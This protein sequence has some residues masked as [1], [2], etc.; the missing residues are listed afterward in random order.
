MLVQEELESCDRTQR[1]LEDALDNRTAELYALR[2]VCTLLLS[3]CIFN[4]ADV[5]RTQL[6]CTADV[7]HTCDV[8]NVTS[9]QSQQ[10]IMKATIKVCWAGC[11]KVDGPMLLL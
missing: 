2:K 3:A 8:I 1:Q 11:Y 10:S 9:L 5:Y 4:S 6:M 7:Y